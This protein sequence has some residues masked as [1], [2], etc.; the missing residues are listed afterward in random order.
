MTT[1]A[2]HDGLYA[3]P[4]EGLTVDRVWLVGPVK[5][6]PPETVEGMISGVE[7]LPPVQGL[8]D[9]VLGVDSQVPGAVAIVRRRDDAQVLPMVRAAVDLLRFFQHLRSHSSHNT[10]FGLPGEVSRSFIPY[11]ERRDD[12]VTA[13]FRA[14]GEPLGW[15]FQGEDHEAWL[16]SE[17]LQW[18]SEAIGEPHPTDGQRRALL[19]VRLLSRAILEPD[20]STRVFLNVVALEAM[21]LERNR[22]AQTYT[23]AVWRTCRAGRCRAALHHLDSRPAPPWPSTRLPQAT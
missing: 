20:P 12:Y 9:Q 7:V 14:D 23:L 2:R 21:L 16:A 6:C 1:P 17:H 3:V 11:L 19:G 13:G 10:M 8:V 22:S 5:V 15:T 18:V 4:I